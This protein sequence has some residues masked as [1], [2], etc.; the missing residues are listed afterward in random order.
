LIRQNKINDGENLALSEKEKM[1]L[2]NIVNKDNSLRQELLKRIKQYTLTEIGKDLS[3]EVFDLVKQVYRASIEIQISEI[4]F[5]PP[6]L[7]IAKRVLSELENLLVTNSR[8]GYKNGNN[9]AKK[10]IEIAAE[11]E[12]LSNYCSSLLCVNLLNQKKLQSYIQEK[13]IFL[14]LDAT[15]F[16]QYLALYGFKNTENYSKEMHIAANLRESIRGLKNVEV[17]ITQEHLEESIR[18]ITQAEKLSSFANDELISQFGDSKNVYF[19]LYLKTKKQKHQSYSFNDFLKSL[20]GY[21]AGL[22][23]NNDNFHLYLDCVLRYLKLANIKVVEFEN[24][25]DLEQD[26]VALKIIRNYEQ[27]CSAIGKSRKF[28]SILNDLT[29]CYILGN[30]NRHLELVQNFGSLSARLSRDPYF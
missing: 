20:I 25:V 14:Y 2:E 23:N 13:F 17:R 15:V 8:N 9:A 12:Y 4:S 5:E 10:L 6:K 3:N 26:A 11:N 21:E 28:K 22:N 27:S 18:H 7:Y 30:G 19:N 1:R 29:A 24:D 16:I